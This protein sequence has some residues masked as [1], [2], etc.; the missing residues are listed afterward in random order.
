MEEMLT[1]AYMKLQIKLILLWYN[2]FSFSDYCPQLSLSL[3]KD[4][5]IMW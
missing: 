1:M 5:V 3:T 2:P 4:T